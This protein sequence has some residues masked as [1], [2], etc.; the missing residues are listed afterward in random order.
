MLRLANGALGPVAALALATGARAFA[1]RTDVVE[2]PSPAQAS[3]KEVV[4]D[5]ENSWKL[6]K[7]KYAILRNKCPAAKLF[8][9]CRFLLVERA[10]PVTELRQC[11]L[12]RDLGFHPFIKCV[13]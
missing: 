2:A 10:F 6:S 12:M 9:D 8:S 11:L 1:L 13:S 3:T 7:S 4:F 5:E